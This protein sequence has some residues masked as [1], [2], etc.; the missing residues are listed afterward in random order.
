[1]SRFRMLPLLLALVLPLSGACE[2]R[3]AEPLAPDATL[4]RAAATP[5]AIASNVW[6]R[7]A[8]LP[9]PLLGAAMAAVPKTDGTSRLFAIGG[10][11]RQTRPGPN[12]PI[13]W[14]APVTTVTEYLPTT[15]RWARRA[16]APYHWQVAPHAAA[17]NGR[18][19]L[20][21]GLR[22]HGEDHLATN[23]MAIYDVAT[24]TWST[25]VMPQYMTANT[26]WTIGGDLFVLG[27]CH[28]EETWVIEDIWDD[29]RR[30]FAPRSFFLRY[31]PTTNTWTY[32]PQVIE[33]RENPVSGGIGGKLYVAAGGSNAL[34][35]YDPGTGVWRGWQPLD[36]ARRLSAGDAVK[37]KLYVAG[38]L[39]L[40]P[41]GTW[42]QSRALS[43][44]NPTTNTWQNRAQ[45]PELFYRN[46]I[47]ATR[48]M[49]GGQA[50]LAILG[51]FGT[52]YQWAPQ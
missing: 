49:I 23:T 37:G 18:I 45:V 13:I 2:D 40:K 51:G 25:A 17:L 28:D 7:L 10:G 11:L 35:A 4:G 42:G 20:P 52:H 9:T 46:E 32:L 21:G 6:V 14:T 8:D 47:R 15:N 19:Y 50:R 12:G 44:Y 39:M 38:G 3:E 43:E 41:D 26:V 48:V 36:R 31:R 22:G 34:D 33:P 5:A 29:C 27:R 30:T 24:N 16:N 1:M